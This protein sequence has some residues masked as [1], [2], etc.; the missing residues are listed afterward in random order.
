MRKWS[1]MIASLL[2]QWWGNLVSEGM[3][4][5]CLGHWQV[6]LE[7]A[8]GLVV[9]HGFLANLTI[10]SFFWWQMQIRGTV[11]SHHM[12]CSII[13]WTYC[14]ILPIT[15]HGWKDAAGMICNLIGLWWSLVLLVLISTVWAQ[16]TKRALTR[17][18]IG[19]AQPVEGWWAPV[20]QHTYKR[21]RWGVS[22]TGSKVR[23]PVAPTNRNPSRSGMCWSGGKLHH[24][25][26]IVLYATGT[27]YCTTPP[28]CASASSTASWKMVAGISNVFPLF[29][30]I[31]IDLLLGIQKLF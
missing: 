24:G 23:R 27:G 4:R 22:G 3:V 12:L 28:S 10:S 20:A 5:T 25:H 1:A 9:I 6:I 15:T 31:Q 18:L 29:K 30:F 14:N 2:L 7:D 16:R 26:I 13:L 11:S 17:A 8:G 19:G 21:K